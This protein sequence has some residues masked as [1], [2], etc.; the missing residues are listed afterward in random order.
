MDHLSQIEK[1]CWAV[2]ADALAFR[3]CVAREENKEYPGIQHFAAVS[4]SAASPEKSIE[5]AEKNDGI[6]RSRVVK[7]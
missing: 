5:Q 7:T 1:L 4:A 6:T 2:L 3:L